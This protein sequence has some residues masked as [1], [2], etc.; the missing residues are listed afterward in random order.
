MTKQFA[1]LEYTLHILF[2]TYRNIMCKK[3]EGVDIFEP[4]YL[5]RFWDLVRLTAHWGQ[6]AI[7]NIYQ[8]KWF[9]EVFYRN[10]SEMDTILDFLTNFMVHKILQNLKKIKS[11]NKI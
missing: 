3:G 11:T 6:K 1:I 2:K 10:R 9:G 5:H 4:A 7:Y 8:R